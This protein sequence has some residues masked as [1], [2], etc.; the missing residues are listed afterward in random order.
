MDTQEIIGWLNS[1]EGLQWSWSQFDN[2]SDC[3]DIIEIYNDYPQYE[4]EDPT[5]SGWYS[6]AGTISNAKAFRRLRAGAPEW[7]DLKWTPDQ[8]PE[9]GTWTKKR[10]QRTPSSS[11]VSPSK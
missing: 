3:H 6:D 7:R 10:K 8:P 9:G 1:D 4:D 2:A 11:T 5:L